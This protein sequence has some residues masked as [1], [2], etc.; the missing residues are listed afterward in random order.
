MTYVFM[1]CV[2]PLWLCFAPNPTFRAKQNLMPKTI[3]HRLTRQSAFSMFSISLRNRSRRPSKY[4][5]HQLCCRSTGTIEA[6]LLSMALRSLSLNT[7]DLLLATADAGTDG[8]TVPSAAEAEAAA[9]TDAVAGD[10]DG[11]AAA[12]VV[13]AAAGA[14]N[15]SRSESSA[16]CESSEFDINALAN[17]L[18]PP[19]TNCLRLSGTIGQ[20]CGRLLRLRMPRSKPTWR[21][22]QFL[23]WQRMTIHMKFG[24]KFVMVIFMNITNHI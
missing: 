11:D 19:R 7:S 14:S 16:P 3:L 1:C 17:S 18:L 8:G 9:A 13:A 22:A 20:C 12:D 15:D 21:E 6:D 24:T 2:W 10:S 5:I 4:V 23:C